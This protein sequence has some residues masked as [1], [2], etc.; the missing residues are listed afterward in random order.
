MTF[1]PQNLIAL[2][3]LLIVGLTVVVVML[4]IAWRRDHF[5]NA[6]LTVIGLNL[7]LLSL[8]FVGH[9][10]AQDV[11]PL[12]R[13][14]GYSMFYIGL[15][16]LASLATSTF[17]YP[18]LEGYP[19]NREEFY[20]LV[21][22]AAMGGILLACANH[23][24]SMFLGIELI[25]LP[26]FGLVGYAYR[27]KR[28]LE[29]SI[30]YMLLSAAASSFLLFGMALLYAESGDL[31]F[32]ALG[33]NLGDAAI[34]QPLLLAG[35]GLMIVGLGFKLSLVPFHLWTPDVYQGAPAP[36]STFLATAS[37]IAIFAV[38]MRLFLYAPVANSEAI[39]V[40]LGIIAFCSILFG[41]IMAISQ[42]NI[43][44]LLGYSS[45]AHLGYLLVALIAVQTHQLS[46]E[47][48]G[49][50]LA[51]YL[52]SSL[53]AFGVVSLMSSPYS[54]PDAESLFS[55]RGLFWHKPILSA[56]MTV[57]MLSLAGIPM[58]LGFI[59]KFYVIATGVTAHLWWLTGAVVV[60]S[61]IGL[62]FYLRVTVCLYL[63]A[64]DK[65]ARDTPIFWSFTAGGVVVLIS[66]ILVLALGIYPQPLISLVQLAQP[67]L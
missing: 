13:V 44:R 65:L 10:G 43:K 45:I 59:G 28:S 66:A 9:A 27:Q 19:D 20:L 29:A 62:F 24:A 63:Y 22:I 34:H 57:M 36:V 51:G 61:A 31:T 40:V 33:K 54:G 17:A 52:F 67:L 39:R 18:W 16:L 3:P 14:D 56:V 26:L 23:L 21:L 50:Y 55:Y 1:T 64:P 47:T 12:L 53:G 58:T 7:A 11:T 35:L 25:S 6:T 5:V 41:N 30:K 15:V 4:S 49:V 38:V 32:A 46:M 48:V 37:K 42:S 8:Y 60:G 2:L